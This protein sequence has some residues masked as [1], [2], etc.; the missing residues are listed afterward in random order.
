M[1]YWVV[2]DYYRLVDAVN[3]LEKR[4]Q[5]LSDDQV[6]GFYSYLKGCIVLLYFICGNVW[7]MQ[8][9]ILV[10]TGKGVASVKFLAILYIIHTFLVLNYKYIQKSCSVLVK[11]SIFNLMFR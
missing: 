6:C 11:D 4:M 1:N 7:I 3:A 5:S 9:R 10:G 2:R 8:R